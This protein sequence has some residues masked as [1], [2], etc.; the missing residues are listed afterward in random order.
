[1]TQNSP[2]QSLSDDDI[3]S[4]PDEDWDSDAD[5]EILDL[6]DFN[7]YQNIEKEELSDIQKISVPPN[8]PTPSP[9]SLSPAPASELLTP[10]ELNTPYPIRYVFFIF[11]HFL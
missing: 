9:P 2:R 7:T 10:A 5:T 6:S 4:K 8:F 11:T 1:M 3:D